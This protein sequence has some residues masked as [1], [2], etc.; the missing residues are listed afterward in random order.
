MAVVASI[1]GVIYESRSGRVEE[2]MEG[3]LSYV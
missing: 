3:L 1:M 2:D